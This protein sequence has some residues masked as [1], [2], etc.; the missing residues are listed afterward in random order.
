VVKE[1]EAAIVK[2]NG[3]SASPHIPASHPAAR[4]VSTSE[5]AEH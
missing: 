1:L 5:A 4:Y 3:P 2:I